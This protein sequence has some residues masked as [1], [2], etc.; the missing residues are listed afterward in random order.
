MTYALISTLSFSLYGLIGRVL[1]V[2]SDNPKAFAAVYNFIAGFF[3]LGFFL[4]DRFEWQPVPV[5]ILLLTGLMVFTYGIFNRTEYVAKKYMEAS[6]FTIVAKLATLFTVILSIV[7]LGESV[8][9][10][11]VI[12]TFLILGANFLLFYRN[13]NFR[14]TKGLKYALIMSFFL[15]L[16]WTI[17]KKAAVYWPLPLYAFLAYAPPNIFVMYFPRIP[18]KT[19]VG[20]F[21]RTSWKVTLLAAMS[22]VGYYFL[23]KG[24]TV[25]EASKVVLINAT[26]SLITIILAIIILKE[27]KDVPLKILAG[28]LAFAGVLLLK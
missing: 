28:L 3:V 2:D 20:E 22:A 25:G 24:F 17:D 6:L 19:L 16:S 5:S 4:V 10:E 11:K 13:G 18:I 27:R 12:A 14:L 23:I 7:L 15:A 1:V 9:V 26:N 8:T 21:R